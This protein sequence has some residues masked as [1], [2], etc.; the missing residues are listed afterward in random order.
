MTKKAL[1]QIM[2]DRMIRRAAAT[3]LATA[4]IFSLGV[5]STPSYANVNE[6]SSVVE[7][8]SEGTTFSA[9]ALASAATSTVSSVK[10]VVETAS[11]SVVKASLANTLASTI[12][13]SSEEEEEAVEV[14]EDTD[15]INTI[16]SETL[17]GI[18][19]SITGNVT[20]SVYVSAEEKEK[21]I[22]MAGTTDIPDDVPE[23]LTFKYNKKFVKEVTA[24]ELDMLYRIV[25]CEAGDQDIFGRILVAN[26]ILNRVDTKGF[27][28]TI[29][30]VILQK[31][32]FQPV[33]TGIFYRA[34]A[35]DLTKKA[36]KRA[37]SGE[38]Y[39]NGATYFF[40][41]SATP[42]ST[43]SWFDTLDKCLKWGVHEFFKD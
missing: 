34:T 7:I 10:N 37:L 24:D 27:P 13:V 2:G 33:T 31:R 1:S 21:M 32:Q 6:D 39:S 5:S 35:S 12:Q 28:D 41:R 26:V 38:D 19:A 29:E 17:T 36:V 20:S 43:A 16:V 15:Y 11:S 22:Q 25:E 8:E 42:K 3:M 30:G 18:T 4:V 40:M 23:G 9:E 14:N